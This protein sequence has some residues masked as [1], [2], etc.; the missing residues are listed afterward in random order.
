MPGAGAWFNMKGPVGSTAFLSLTREGSYTYTGV[1]RRKYG[2]F[3]LLH[4]GAAKKL[5]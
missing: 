3:L 2:Y 5:G 4:N 1:S